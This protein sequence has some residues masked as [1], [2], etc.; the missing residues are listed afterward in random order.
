MLEKIIEAADK[1]WKSAAWLLER[2]YGYRKDAVFDEIPEQQDDE[3]SLPSTPLELF[4]AQAKDLRQAMSQAMASQS[5]QAYAALQRQYV[6][7]VDQMRA[8]QAEQAETDALDAASDEHLRQEA[9]MAIISLPPVLRQ[10]IID[11]L[12]RY[13]NVI[14]FKK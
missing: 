4:E 6:S 14:A 7:V 5:W 3:A 12:A 1:D 2:R 13:N 10:E 8:I 11:E 9:V